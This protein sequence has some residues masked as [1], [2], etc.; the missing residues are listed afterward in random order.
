VGEFS[1]LCAA[2]SLRFEDALKIAVTLKP[3]N[4]FRERE[5][6]RERETRNK[7]ERDKVRIV[8]KILLCSEFEVKRCR[9][10][11]KERIK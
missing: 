2:K 8:L 1:A 9:K 5:R 3:F 4:K 11:Q 7:D 10:P 6:E